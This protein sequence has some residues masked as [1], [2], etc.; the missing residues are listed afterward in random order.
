MAEPHLF[1]TSSGT[2][3][4]DPAALARVFV[5]PSFSV[6]WTENALGEVTVDGSTATYTSNGD[7]ELTISQSGLEIWRE[8]LGNEELGLRFLTGRMMLN[9]LLYLNIA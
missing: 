6:E 3:E 2:G 8:V 4:I 9:K 1:V 7:A 5:E